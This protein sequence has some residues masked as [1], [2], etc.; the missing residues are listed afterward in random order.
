MNQPLKASSPQE[1][2]IGGPLPVLLDFRNGGR[3]WRM[4][5]GALVQA[6]LLG[7]VLVLPLLVT[8]SFTARP[9][10]PEIRQTIRLGNP[11]GHVDGPRP[12]GPKP[13]R[14]PLNPDQVYLPLPTRPDTPAPNFAGFGDPTVGDG[15]GTEDRF[16]HPHGDPFSNSPVGSP[17]SSRGP[18]PPPPPPVATVLKG[19]EVRP[20][21]LIHRV[22]PEYPR[23]AKLA[24]IQ[25]DVVLEALLDK[26]GRVRNVEVKSGPTMLTEAA[27]EAVSQWVY[28]PTYLNGQPYPVLLTVTVEFR[29][30]R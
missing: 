26:D 13:V 30:K 23:L 19:G 2:A 5:L 14:E 20:P 22:E 21:K 28:E 12:P 4:S 17:L 24:G 11:R 9:E 3:G 7:L 1:R 6:T 15:S 10:P 8:E 16:G 27:R 25:G 18:Q 29:L